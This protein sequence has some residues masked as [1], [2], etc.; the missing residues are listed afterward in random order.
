MQNS[1]NQQVMFVFFKIF[2]INSFIS[3]QCS[4]HLYHLAVT[5]SLES[6][7][8]IKQLILLVRQWTTSTHRSNLGQILRSFQME[9]KLPLKRIP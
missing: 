2:N 3:F 4:A 8:R 6:N 1:R 9:E 5:E 7:E